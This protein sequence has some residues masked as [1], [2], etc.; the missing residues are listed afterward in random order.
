MKREK[1]I[2]LFN[3]KIS[4]ELKMIKYRM[5]QKTKE[6]LYASAYEVDCTICIFELLKEM[7]LQMDIELLNACLQIPSLINFLYLEWL[8]IDDNRNAELE[9]SLWSVLKEIDEKIA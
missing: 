3:W 6:E 4:S 8:K 2:E 7:S 1:L 9:N 5:L